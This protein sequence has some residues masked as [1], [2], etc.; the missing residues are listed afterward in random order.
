MAAYIVITREKTR[1]TDEL[2]KYKEESQASYKEHEITVRAIHGKFEVLEGAAAEE[3]FILEFASYDEAKAWY[4][5]DTYQGAS[6]HRFQGGDYRFILT[7]GI[8]AK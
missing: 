7:E 1:N 4:T 5:S 6:R 3:I 2:Q 8:P